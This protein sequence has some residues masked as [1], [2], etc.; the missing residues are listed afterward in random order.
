MAQLTDQSLPGLAVTWNILF[1][2]C[3]K[4]TSCAKLGLAV[5]SAPLFVWLQT[6]E[7]QRN[8]Y[9]YFFWKSLLIWLMTF[10]YIYLAA[11]KLK[12]ERSKY[13][14]YLEISCINIFLLSLNCH[15]YFSI[16]SFL[17]S[18]SSCSL[19]SFAVNFGF[20]ASLFTSA[21]SAVVW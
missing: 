1:P 20:C 11:T 16:V 14:I 21:C 8:S 17:C 15:P 13:N 6:A 2:V 5:L 18:G 10:F 19:L 4:N 9:S 3:L 7:S 12:T